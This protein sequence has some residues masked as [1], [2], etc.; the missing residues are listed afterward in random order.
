MTD[1]RRRPSRTGGRKEASVRSRQGAALSLAPVHDHRCDRCGYQI[2]TLA[3]F[4]R[5]PMCGAEE[6]SGIGAE[7]RE[8]PAAA[9]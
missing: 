2:A 9:R 5:C 7:S 6:W 4:P 1:R 3:P 8:H